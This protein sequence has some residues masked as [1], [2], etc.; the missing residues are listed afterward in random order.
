MGPWAQVSERGLRVGAK[1]ATCMSCEQRE[2]HRS[3]ACP[4]V[5]AAAAPA[6]LAG[7]PEVSDPAPFPA[8]VAVSAA[9]LMS[10]AAIADAR[11]RRNSDTMAM[12]GIMQQRMPLGPGGMAAGAGMGVGMGGGMG[13]AGM[14]ATGM[15]AA[16]MGP[17]MALGMGSNMG[18]GGMGG[19]GMGQ[20]GV[21]TSTSGRLMQAGG[22]MGGGMAGMSGPLGTMQG[23]A[24]RTSDGNMVI[25]VAGS[26]G[27]LQAL[28]NSG[29]MGGIG[30]T[31]TS[32]SGAVAPGATTMVGLDSAPPG[33]DIS[34]LMQ[35]KTRRASDVVA[36]ASQM[37]ML[38]AQQQGQQQ[39][40]GMQGQGMGTSQERSTISMGG[41][42]AAIQGMHAF[43]AAGTSTAAP[44]HSQQQQQQLMMQAA[45]AVTGLS[46]PPSMGLPT[47]VSPGAPSSPL[48]MSQS[49]LPTVAS[50]PASQ[51]PSPQQTLQDGG[52]SMNMA[53]LAAALGG[54]R[55]FMA[56]AN[57]S[58]KNAGSALNP[59]PAAAAAVA[60][61]TITGND[62]AS[63]EAKLKQ[64]AALQ[65]QL[66]ALQQ[67]KAQREKAQ[68]EASAAAA[69][70][71]YPVAGG[72]AGMQA[73]APAA[74]MQQQ[75]GL[76]DDDRPSDSRA[77]A[78]RRAQ[79]MARQA[80]DGSAMHAAAA[81]VGAMLDGE[82]AQ[83]GGEGEAARPSHLARR[84][85]T[86]NN[87]R[88]DKVLTAAADARAGT[89][90]G[91]GQ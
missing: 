60:A 25:G 12:A 85:T 57:I 73:G 38:A 16:G 14:G 8:T 1:G 43:M 52:G 63:K 4:P 26:T 39:A 75:R 44:A 79:T 20:A 74:M 7:Y 86:W 37:Q 45:A 69:A 33:M 66:Q 11:M 41:A 72:V 42:A 91:V 76:M 35:T 62:A 65:A 54:A 87:E 27:N 71:G 23:G 64:L 82:A 59:T 61:S 80:A 83:R 6:A 47:S 70:S 5:H 9:L 78:G 55:A 18:A 21:D 50:Q 10:P 89:G 68:R 67:M 32:N 84:S 34:D 19:M 30:G 24:M 3:C 36:F 17:A 81:A 40:M 49:G 77:F 46:R 53:S 22:G 90:S 2:V 58:S 31:G 88:F 15:G 13:S 56:N 51:Q 29:G 28:L 48:Q